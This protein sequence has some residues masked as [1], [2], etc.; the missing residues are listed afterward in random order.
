MD[1]QQAIAAPRV[2]FAEPNSL[3]VEQGIPE[4]V[5]E[6]L[7]ALGHNIRAGSLGNG[8]GLAIEYDSRGKPFRFT[9][10]ADPR[11]GGLAKGY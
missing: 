9:G 11:G 2:S 6:Q 4:S 7:T 1:V 3:S 10:G 8:H 5:R